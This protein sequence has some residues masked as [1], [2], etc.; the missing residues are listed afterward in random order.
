MS[1]VAWLQYSIFFTPQ[2]Y[3]AQAH[4]TWPELSLDVFLA[5]TQDHFWMLHNRPAS[6]VIVVLLVRWPCNTPQRL[7]RKLVISSCHR[8]RSRNRYPHPERCGI[9]DH[10]YYI[11]SYMY[12]ATQLVWSIVSLA[13]LALSTLPMTTTRNADWKEKPNRGVSFSMTWCGIY[14]TFFFFWSERKYEIVK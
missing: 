8:L 10:F 13:L 4:S 7:G 9:A 5:T 11:L 1:H 14:A 2:A 6:Q 12:S 3:Q